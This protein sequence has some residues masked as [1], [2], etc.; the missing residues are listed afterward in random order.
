[1]RN[2]QIFVLL[3][4]VLLPLSGCMDN[5]V[6][7]VEGTED[8]ESTSTVVNNTTVVNNYYNQTTN[9]PP[10]FYVAG[11][12]YLS[13]IDYRYDDGGRISTYDS[14]SG[15]ELSRM[16]HTTF[17]FWFSVTDV[18]SNITSVGL[19]LDLDQIIDHQFT[20]NESWSNF[21]YHESPGIAQSN[22]SLAN[23]QMH[24]EGGSNPIYCYARFNLMAFDDDGGVQVI[25][26]ALR[27]DDAVPHDAA[28]CQDDY[29]G[30]EER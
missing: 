15:D 17:R 26:Y 4:V 21:T 28:S 27:M 9:Q 11:V 19:D 29:T 8:V 3:L 10:Q 23:W 16:Y 18:D 1:M 14:S 6:G 20:T 12:G 22:G 24:Y 7:E 5:A 2:D 30:V 13:D 25:P